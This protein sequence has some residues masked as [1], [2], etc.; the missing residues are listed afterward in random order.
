MF[1]LYA[2]IGIIGILLMIYAKIKDWI[3]GNQVNKDEAK[4]QVDD[5]AIATQTQKITT[6]QEAL[7]EALNKYRSDK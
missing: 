3:L 6:D 7:N 4:T 1:K 5:T 2:G